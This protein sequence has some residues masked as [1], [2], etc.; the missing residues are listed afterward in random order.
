MVELVFITSNAAKLAHIKHLCLE[1]AVRISKQK[2][3][4][5][6]YI[7][8]RIENRDELIKQSIEDAITRFKK[9][10]SSDNNFFFIEDTSVVIR[11]LSKEKEY[12][13]VDIKYWMKSNTFSSLDESLKEQG[14]DRAAT[15]RSDIIL[16]L[17]EDLQK[18]LN[19]VYKIFKSE[20]SGIITESEFEVK[21]QPLYP[22]LNEKT[23]NKWFIPYGADLPMSLLS[24]EEADKYDFRAG[25]VKE[26]L[27][28]L[29]DNKIL[30]RKED[31]KKTQSAQLTLFEPFTFIICGPTC[32]GK[33]TLA[34]HLA[35]KYGY[36][37]LEASDFMYQSFYERH[38]LKST[39]HIADFAE[40]ALKETPSIVADQIINN[41][42]NLKHTPFVITGFRNIKEIESFI[43][44]NKDGLAIKIIYVN[45]DQKIRYSRS[46][47]RARMDSVKTVEEFA[48]RDAQQHQMGLT[49]IKEMSDKFGFENDLAVSDFYNSFEDVFE[50]QLGPNTNSL[51]SSFQANNRSL[52]NTI[53]LT[54]YK[55]GDKQRYFTTTEIARL[56]ET[57]S[58]DPKNKNNIS[59]YFNQNFHPYFEIK[60]TGDGTATYRLSQTGVAYAKFIS[61]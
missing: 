37:H 40:A 56:T 54:L 47:K 15:V 5:I 33:T 59:R 53:V 58:T 25:A 7:E 43:S 52:Q 42:S 28:F 44:Q 18:K 34:T 14:N 30:H 19:I 24:I 36:Y 31:F 50:S 39:V 3:Y 46:L 29:H 27:N 8:P 38:G 57:Y 10:V 2:N 35:D 41:V 26:M 11:A 12:P 21:T 49:T 17:S 13:G 6:G 61:R 23:F 45:A 1:Y 48:Q 32:A 55:Q 51:N 16:V 20:T 4:G 22:W 9:T 60:I